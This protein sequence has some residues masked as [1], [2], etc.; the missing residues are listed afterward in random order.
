MEFQRRKK[1]FLL[2]GETRGGF[3]KGV[4]FYASLKDSESFDRN[5]QNGMAGIA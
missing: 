5:E 3:T 1:Y 2:T 4:V